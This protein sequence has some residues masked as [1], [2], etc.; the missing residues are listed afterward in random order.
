MRKKVRKMHK[1]TGVVILMTA[2]LLCAGIPRVS[3]E[4]DGQKRDENKN[5]PEFRVGWRAGFKR[6]VTGYRIEKFGWIGGEFSRVK[7]VYEMVP[8]CWYTGHEMDGCSA[9][10]NC[11]T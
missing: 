3:A 4:G 11:A 5:D 7:H 6:Q 1:K 2:L 9:D 8:C 10:K